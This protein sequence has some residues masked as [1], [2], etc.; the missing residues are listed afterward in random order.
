MNLE[1]LKRIIIRTPLENPAKSL[2]SLLGIT[3]Y[4]KNPELREIY[5]ESDRL[6]NIFKS[7]ILPDFNCIDIGCHLGSTLSQIIQLAPQ[8]HHIA[9]E[10]IPYK[11]KWLKQKFPE[12]EIKEVALSDSSNEV[13][14]YVDKTKSGFSGLHQHRKKAEEIEKITV[15]CDQL[16]EVISPDYRIDFIKVDV[17]GGELAVLKGAKN[18]LSKFHPIILFECTLSGLSSFNFTS[19][20]VFDFL[21]TQYSYQIFLP[22]DFLENGKPLT[23]DEFNNALQYPFKAFNFIA[24]YSN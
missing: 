19:Q 3:Q 6:D 5:R 23:Y 11:A 15:H 18:T 1:N 17:E 10:P 14:F 4:Y 24:I 8:G 16:D 12:V 2:R 7:V 22:K 9:F 13:D 21:T 20:E